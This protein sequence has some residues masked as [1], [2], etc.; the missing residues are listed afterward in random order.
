MVTA[1][2]VTM[3]TTEEGGEAVSPIFAI[4]LLTLARR[5]PWHLIYRTCTGLLSE[6]HQKAPPPPI[7]L[8]KPWDF[9]GG[10]AP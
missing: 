7:G 6:R 8:P 9:C 1:S 4:S 5:G 3:E 10:G 2:L